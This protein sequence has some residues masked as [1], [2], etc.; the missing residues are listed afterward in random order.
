MDEI[1][2][3]NLDKLIQIIDELKEKKVE[4]VPM[5]YIISAFFP[6][7]YDNIKEL[8]ARSYMEGY[9]E[10]RKSILEDDCK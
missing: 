6:D 10:G 5:E 4:K 3:V 8:V 2:Y 1:S 9:N 7:A